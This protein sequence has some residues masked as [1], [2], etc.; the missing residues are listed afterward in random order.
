[1]DEG[2]H[3]TSMAGTWMAIVEGFGGKQVR[4]GKL[5]LHPLI[6]EKWQQY[7][8]RLFL[9]DHSLQVT[10]TRESV[11]LLYKGPKPIVVNVY[12]D[13]KKV[14]PNETLKIKRVA[15]SPPAGLSATSAL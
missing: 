13:D 12:D 7:S 5:F 1:V 3:I 4:H 10:V 14:F 2:L 11:S 8:F 9:K 15:T 6:H